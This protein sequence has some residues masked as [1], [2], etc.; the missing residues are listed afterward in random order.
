MTPDDLTQA[1][2]AGDVDAMLELGDTLAG[3]QRGIDAARWYEAAAATGELTAPRQLGDLYRRGCGDLAP[4]AQRAHAWYARSL[5]LHEPMLRDGSDYAPWALLNVGELLLEGLGAERDEPRAL[6]LLEQSRALGNGHAGHVLA[7]HWL[8]DPANAQ[9][10][11][12]GIAVLEAAAADPYAM[13]QLA[14]WYGPYGGGTDLRRECHWL[15]R[16]A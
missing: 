16:L 15:E 12:R 9:D 13:S 10:V 14:S 1:A 3:E 7:R 11:A 8:R 5:A 6:A 4:D 2:E